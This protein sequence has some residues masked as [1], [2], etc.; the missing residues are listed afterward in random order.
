MDRVE[1]D[2]ID[3]SKGVYSRPVQ[4]SVSSAVESA[5]RIIRAAP[6]IPYSAVPGILRCIPR[7]DHYVHCPVLHA[8][9]TAVCPGTALIGT[10][11]NSRTISK[12]SCRI[13]P[14]RIG[15]HQSSVIQ[16]A[17]IKWM[18]LRTPWCSTLGPD[19][20][21]VQLYYWKPRCRLSRRND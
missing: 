19:S 20:T 2:R 11:K 6:I 9:V 5:Q 12:F 18:A 7:V 4:A 14:A 10:D 16:H 21:G 1:A 13:D 15:G 17:D 8:G 3:L